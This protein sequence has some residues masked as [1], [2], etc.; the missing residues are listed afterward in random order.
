MS[1]AT[2]YIGLAWLPDSEEHLR[3]D[4]DLGLKL[5]YFEP[6]KMSLWSVHV[7]TLLALCY[8]PALVITSNMKRSQDV[9]WRQCWR[10]EPN[11]SNYNCPY[12]SSFAL[13]A[14]ATCV[15]FPDCAQAEGF[16]PDRHSSNVPCT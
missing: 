7:T 16:L 6:G 15:S 9:S 8:S 12:N 2:R 4:V 1:L 13:I 11:R 5:T 3:F 14:D 10:S